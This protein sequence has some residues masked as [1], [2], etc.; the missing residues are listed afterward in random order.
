MSTLLIIIGIVFLIAGIIGAILP[1]IPGP[2]LSFIGM[3]FIHYSSDLYS[4]KPLTL[5]IY[6]IVSIT[7]LV[8]DYIIPAMGT[9]KYGGTKYGTWG[10][11]IGLL[12]AVV[13]FPILGIVLGPFGIIGI[14]LG[15]FAGAYIGEIIGG[16]NHD[17]A[18][19]SGLGSFYG[20]LAGT[21][22]KLAYAII[23]GV[24]CLWHLI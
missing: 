19:K 8:L 22:L 10:S 24:T 17:D 7:I 3:L 15:P 23:V 5:V 18:L 14:I 20:F 4:F 9:K 21:F 1:V 16:K 12:I 13:I 6:G 11:T 2:P